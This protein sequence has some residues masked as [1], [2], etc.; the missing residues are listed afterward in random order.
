MNKTLV[1]GILILLIGMSVVSST[2]KIIED[3]SVYRN[4]VE[5]TDNLLK[6]KPVDCSPLKSVYSSE[7]KFSQNTTWYMFKVGGYEGTGFYAFYPNGTYRFREWE[8]DDFFSGGTWTNDGR[9]LCCMHENGTLY[10]INPETFDAY[11]IGDGDV[12]LNGLAYNPVNEKLYGASSYDLYEID[13]E[14]G[15]QTCIGG[16][17]GDPYIMIAIAFDKY[18]VLYGWD[19]GNDSLWIIDNETGN[20]TLVGPLGWN[21]NFAQDGAFEYDTDILYLAAYTTGMEGCLLECDEDTGECTF[22]GNFEGNAEF[23]AHAI[24]YE[25][26]EPP[27]T[28]HTLDPPKP[29]GEN[30]WY[31]SDVNVTLTATDDLSGVKEIRY[32][33]NGGPE[34]VISGDNGTFIIHDDSEDILV[35]YW[36]I[37]NAGNVERTNSFMVD[38]DQTEPDTVLCYEIVGGNWLFGWDYEFS[39]QVTDAMSGFNITYYRIDGGEWEIYTEPFTLPDGYDIFIEYYSVDYAGNV[40]DVNSE[41]VSDYCIVV[42][43]FKT[44][45]N[46]ATY[47]PMFYWFLERFSLLERLLN[48]I[49]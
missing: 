9:Y 38:I 17:G 46:K 34:G 37:D 13:I 20:A 45:R 16:F 11:A 24:S 4:H 2:G 21:L 28:T 30:G 10:D 12:S 26:N 1:I 35:E 14:T 48:L 25:D 42:N 36:A 44:P 19:V 22:V 39:L 41:N 29:D 15:N 33:I 47:Y 18:G 32:T 49:R 8:G 3:V 23:T 40:E 43:V 5:S 31:V 7:K 27:V 6:E